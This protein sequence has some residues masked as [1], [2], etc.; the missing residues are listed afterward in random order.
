MKITIFGLSITSS[1]GNGHATTYRALCNALA[2]RGHEIVFF[3]QDA[4]WYA[5]NRDVEGLPKIKIIRYQQ[6]ADVRSRAQAELRDADVAVVGS[7][8][9][10]A[11]E[12]LAE[13]CDSRAGVKAFY[14][15]DTPITLS[16]LRET[17][18]TAY[19]RAADIPEL[20][21]YL[22]FTGGPALRD[23]ERDFG[24]RRA[25]ALYCSV[26]T[27]QYRPLG[28]NKD[29]ACE[30]SYMGTYAPDR[31]PKL[32]ELLC[33]PARVMPQG[34]FIVAGPQY[35]SPLRWPENVM[36]IE[37]LEPKYHP[38]LYCSS[39]LVLNVTRRDMVM[40]GYSPSVRIFEAAACG[41]TII[42]DNW[43]GLDTFFIP[44]KEILTASSR[45]EVLRYL[46]DYDVNELNRIGEQARARILAEH[47]S[48]RRAQ[49]FEEFVSAA[50]SKPLQTGAIAR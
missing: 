35:P 43:P 18:Q 36:R 40:A 4:E 39:R 47:S 25:V 14:D 26:D 48:D 3:E 41:A 10:N 50:T 21:I 12:A 27:D 30:M 44:G 24:A 2:K 33:A 20:D 42:S 23:L 9:P 17:G 46:K 32:D 28:V 22:S 8:F 11:P 29:F 1:W 6:W 16:Q 38:H 7:Y 15:I 19:L 45:A 13:M 5:N 49:Q 31:Q 37:H 34:R